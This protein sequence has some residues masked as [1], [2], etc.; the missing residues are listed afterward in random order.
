MVRGLACRSNERLERLQGCVVVGLL[1]HLRHR[2][3][4]DDLAFGIDGAIQH[5]AGM[6][7]SKCIVAVNT[8]KDAPI[9]NVADVGI[10]GDLFD[11]VP[12]L[13]EKI[14]ELKG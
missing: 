10:V 3:G 5:L 13:E 8:K 14:R 4:I 6:R 1:G 11:I 7:G 9:F 12:L 2:L